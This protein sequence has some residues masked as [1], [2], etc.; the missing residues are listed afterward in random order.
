M[1]RPAD[2]EID[3]IGLRLLAIRAEL[4]ALDERAK[5]LRQA[6][7]ALIRR[8]LERRGWKHAARM[9]GVGRTRLYAM[10]AISG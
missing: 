9:L 8:L 3:R 2:D 6:R 4:K 1:S 10:R 5:E 7:A